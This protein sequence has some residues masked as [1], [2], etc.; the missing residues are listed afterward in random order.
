MKTVPDGMSTL[1]YTSPGLFETVLRK[2][3]AQYMEAVSTP[4]ATRRL[5]AE[6]RAGFCEASFRATDFRDAYSKSATN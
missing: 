5:R 2:L 1:G 4:S 6:E 3:L